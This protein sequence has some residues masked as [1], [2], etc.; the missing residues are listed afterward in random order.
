MV[1]H[2]PTLSYLTVP[3]FKL[4]FSNVVLTVGIYFTY[5]IPIIPLL[6]SSDK[7]YFK[8]AP[9]VGLC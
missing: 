6:T 1:S 8:V 2:D 5:F 4:I 7:L 9:L 3:N